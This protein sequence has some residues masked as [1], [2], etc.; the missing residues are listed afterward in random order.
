MKIFSFILIAFL[1]SQA[2]ADMF[3]EFE[4][5]EGSK[6]EGEY[7]V[8]VGS[9]RHV[10]EYECKRKGREVKCTSIAQNPFTAAEFNSYFRLTGEAAKTEQSIAE[11]NRCE[12]TYEIK[13][14]CTGSGLARCNGQDSEGLQKRREFRQIYRNFR[15]G[16]S[17][18]FES[19]AEGRQT[20]L[21]PAERTEEYNAERQRY[22]DGQNQI[23]ERRQRIINFC[24]PDR[25][26]EAAHDVFAPNSE[27]PICL[28]RNGG[29]RTIRYQD[30]PAAAPAAVE[31]ANDAEVVE[32]VNTENNSSSGSDD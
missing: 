19:L 5:C 3:N 21:S 29:S 20:R 18:R 11:Y 6:C 30:V 12:H 23:A 9:T 32:A 8:N 13:A 7:W 22:R 17:A 26:G 25:S 14:R 4:N 31:V 10:I 1:C 24:G 15:S 16:H 27:N 28:W 2:S